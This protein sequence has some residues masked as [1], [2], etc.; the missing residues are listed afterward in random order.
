MRSIEDRVAELESRATRYRNAL[1]AVVVTACAVAVTGATTDDVQE[2][3]KTRSLQIV[4]KRGE[5]VGVFEALPMEG[6]EL[7]LHNREGVRVA[8]LGVGRFGGHLNLNFPSGELLYIGPSDTQNAMLRL[9]NKDGVA[10]LQVRMVE[11]GA[12][13]TLHNNA[14]VDVV[15]V[16][17]DERGDGVVYVGD[18]EG[19]GGN[20]KPRP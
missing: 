5:T 2:V 10:N 16:Y 12:K 6:A 4:N 13:L 7:R 19:N 18:H 9:G 3:V 11:H 15:Q 20:L 14:L 8:R 1:L 17:V